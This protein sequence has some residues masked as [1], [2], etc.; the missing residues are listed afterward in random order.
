LDATEDLVKKE[1]G[2]ICL[3]HAVNLGAGCATQTGYKYAKKHGYNYVI[4]MDADYQHLPNEINSLLSEIKKNQVD[5]VIGSRFLKNGK[6]PYYKISLIRRI[7]MRLFAKLASFIMHQKIT[8]STS[9]FR[10]LNKKTINFLADIDYPDDFQD[11][12]VLI[13]LKLAGFKIKE[14][15]VKMQP[16][17]K[18][19]SM[20]TKLK[21]L[22]YIYKMSL[23]I[24][25]N[26]LRTHSIK[27][28][29]C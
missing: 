29:K 8:D 14:I 22:Y 4:Q 28:K 7:G 16:R 25:I 10:A 19:K 6:T 11:A 9:C 24:I 2:V 13:F 17:I 21:I 1:K 15:P 20:M 18:G 12:D 3:S 27:E 5:M 23:S 26:L